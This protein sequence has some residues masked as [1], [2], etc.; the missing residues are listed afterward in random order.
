MSRD[1]RDLVE[2]PPAIP[3]HVLSGFLGAGKTT[4]VRRLLEKRSAHERIAV[5]VNEFGDIGVDGALLSDCMSCVLKEV[6]GGC[7]C[8]TA[9]ADLEAS[10]EEMMGLVFP[11]RIVVEPTGLAR[12]SEIVD[13]LRGV[14]W[15]GRFEVRPVVTFL[16][17]LLDV[18]ARYEEGGLFREQLDV[19]DVLVVTRTD[20]APE[21]R[22]REVEAFASALAPPKMA[23][24][25]AANGDVPDLAWD[26]PLPSDRDATAV[27]SAAL[28]LLPSRPAGRAHVDGG[29][30]V[31][32]HEGHGF[33]HGPERVVDADL[34]A[35]LFSDLAAGNL[36]NGAVARAKGVFNTTTG[37]RSFEIAGGRVST[38]PTVYRRDNRF[39]V[40]L[41][42]P[43]PGDF[44]AIGRRFDGALVADGAPLLTVDGAAG[45][46]RAFDFRA[47]ERAGRGPVRLGEL[48]RRADAESAPFVWLVS[49]GGL[50]GAGAPRAALEAGLVHYATRDGRPIPEEE[51]G[52]FRFE[53]PDDA[54]AGH[55]DEVD[56]CRDVPALCGIRVVATPGAAEGGPV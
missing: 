43:A 40:V 4:A 30:A 10:I 16:D 3:V 52:P 20:V 12:P 14:R 42:D 35:D 56:R 37:W 41:R 11:T 36:A 1:P 19:G 49:D 51:G 53:L 15:A 18:R 44:E 2:A 7:V 47:L 13:L 29:R 5:I 24:F 17:P 54:A 31:E 38:A 32:G 21:E 33:R 26:T 39:D 46:A 55:E 25:R 9:M 50:F 48:L 22:L 23:V 8:C 28:S 27:P 34:L 6:P 45:L